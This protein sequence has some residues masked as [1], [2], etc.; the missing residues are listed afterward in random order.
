[1]GGPKGLEGSALRPSQ[2]ITYQA[3]PGMVGDQKAREDVG[4]RAWA[5]CKEA[6]RAPA[7]PSHGGSPSQPPF[8]LGHGRLCELMRGPLSLLVLR[9]GTRPSQVI[10]AKIKQDAGNQD[11]ATHI[12]PGPAFC[13]KHGLVLGIKGG[14]D[15]G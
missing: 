9:Q 10:G 4:K 13:L 6:P 5:A 1:M 12:F 2:G 14:S 8:L 11:W 15:C 7:F 3:L